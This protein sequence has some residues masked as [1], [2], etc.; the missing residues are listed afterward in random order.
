MQ[1]ITSTST[2]PTEEVPTTEVGGKRIV[3][4]SAGISFYETLTNFRDADEFKDV[5]GK[6]AYRATDEGSH[7]VYD[8]VEYG[9]ENDFSGGP[10]GIDGKLA[11]DTGTVEKYFVVY[12]GKEY[13]KE[14]D[15]S[16]P[17]F[18]FNGKLAY[19]AQE[20]KKY[21]IVADGKTVSDEYDWIDDPVLM[22][23]SKLAYTAWNRTTNTGFLVY[24][25]VKVGKEYDGVNELTSI[26]GKPA[27][28]AGRDKKNF[29]VI[30][31]VEEPLDYL[32]V[33]ELIDVNG[34]PAYVAW[35]EAPSSP[36]TGIAFVVYDG[37]E[38]K[39]YRDI[40]GLT[41][42]NGKIA[43]AATLRDG[44]N[45]QVIVY[46]G[47]EYGSQYDEVKF[48]TKVGDKL[49]YV[50]NKKGVGDIVVYDGKELTG[51]DYSSGSIF[52][53]LA[54]VNGKLVYGMQTDKGLSI[55]EEV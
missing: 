40:L 39:E 44:K 1:E 54:S 46:D 12:D 3:T 41:N 53:L 16:G 17:A 24:N 33:T 9:K 6:L 5:N 32:G 31:G 35:T 38:G 19:V 34:K 28:F 55:M 29:L 11:Y 30:D 26:G 37:K 45:T 14:Y 23:G 8:G 52:R 15:T 10:V 36:D 27:F 4:S 7:L 20:N 22:I 2:T 21:F 51:S 48:P 42:I 50:A 43:Y 13:G 18:D 25:G 49:V 47:V